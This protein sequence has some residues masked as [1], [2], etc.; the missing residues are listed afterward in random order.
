MT[1]SEI[2]TFSNISPFDITIT[3]S[4][5][6]HNS[7]ENIFESHIHDNCEIY[8]NVSGDVSFVVEGNIYP[9]H[10]GDVIITRPYEYHNCVYNGTSLHRHF[11]ILIK[12]F[13]SPVLD[14]FFK[15]TAGTNNLLLLNN[16]DKEKLISLCTKMATENLTETEKYVCFFTLLNMLE[17]ATTEVQSEQNLYYP[18]TLTAIKYINNMQNTALTI[19]EIADAAHVS[20]RTLERH[21]REDLKTS[22]ASYIK[23]LRMS[24]ATELLSTRLSVQQVCEKCGFADYS[25]FIS[26]FKKIYGITPLKFKKSCKNQSYFSQEKTDLV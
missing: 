8:I 14:I 10:H 9:V 6:N 11:W 7:P 19:A 23:K 17:K 24:K 13:N 15:R 22:P 2:I 16:S 18:D 20:I 1:K 21:F 12:P 3:Y 4:E 25:R 5:L 26:D